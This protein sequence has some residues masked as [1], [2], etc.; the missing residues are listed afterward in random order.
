MVSNVSAKLVFIWMMENA[1]S[2]SLVLLIAIAKIISAFVKIIIMNLMDF[3][4][5]VQRVSF[6]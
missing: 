1:F 2:E 6:I 4:Q 5:N 3:V